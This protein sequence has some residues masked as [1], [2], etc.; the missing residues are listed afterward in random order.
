MRGSSVVA[1]QVVIRRIIIPQA[2]EPQGCL[3]LVCNTCLYVLPCLSRPFVCSCSCFMA[4]WLLCVQ[5]LGAAGPSA[6]AAAVS[7]AAAATAVGGSAAAGRVGGAAVGCQQEE[8]GPAAA[9]AAAQEAVRAWQLAR[10][11]VQGS[12][13]S[14]TEV[15]CHYLCPVLAVLDA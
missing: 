2:A 1:L 13:N 14:D 10:F 4:A 6:A 5:V 12:I 3:Q 9:A 15:F 8:L 7:T 11:R